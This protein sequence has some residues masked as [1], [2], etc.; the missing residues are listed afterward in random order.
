MNDSP[1]IIDAHIH[2]GDN[3]I[4]SDADTSI[5][6]LV[7]LMDR[8]GISRCC[9]SHIA[10]INSHHFEYAN[11]ETSKV[12]R[13]Y[14]KRIFGYAIYNPVFRKDS[15]DNVKR[16]LGERGFIGI[17]IYPTTHR[18]PINGESYDPL[19]K[20][21]NDNRIPVLVHTWD[22][23]PQDSLPHD[24]SSVYAQPKLVRDVKEKYPKLIIIMA[25][26]GAHYNGHLQAIEIVKNYS[27]TYV[28]TS[29]D[30]ISF[31]LIEWFVRE[32]G[33]DRVLYGSDMNWLDPRAH[34]GRVLGANIGMQE[35]EMILYKNAQ[36]LFDFE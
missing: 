19:W 24:P 27:N 10:G 11:G 2:I 21:A 13:E 35:K 3:P 23:T 9:G 14:P 17:K 1:S 4:D 30:T 8:N 34:I 20:Y 6:S 22:A 15:L 25:H 36:S 28:D 26:G 33:A 29:G 18:H 16:H 31:G 12:L 7:D 5:K 32:T